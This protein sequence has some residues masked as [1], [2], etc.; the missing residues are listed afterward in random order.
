MEEERKAKQEEAKKLREAE[1]A[2]N[3]KPPQPQGKTL[4]VRNIS[5][6]TTQEDLTAFMTRFGPVK[7]AVLCK[8]K[9]LEGGDDSG[10]LQ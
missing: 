1:K 6:D 10:T 2:A 5:Y 7:Y 8:P 3:P 4:F 9:Q